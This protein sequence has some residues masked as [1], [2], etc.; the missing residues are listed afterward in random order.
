MNKLSCNTWEY[1]HANNDF[2]FGLSCAYGHLGVAKWLL[3]LGK[4]LNSPINIHE[5]DDYAFRWSCINGHL[6]VYNLIK[7]ELKII[8]IKNKINQ[9]TN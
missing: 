5:N 8:I 1:I 2:A 6:E 9:W 4:E 7:I 3:D